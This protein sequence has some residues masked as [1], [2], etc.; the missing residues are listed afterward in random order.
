MRFVLTYD[1][2]D[3]K[4]RTKLSK[5]L[6]QFGDR[7]QYSVFELELPEYK[8]IE[9]KTKINRT[10]EKFKDDLCIFIYPICSSCKK[11]IHRVGNKELI[12]EKNVLLF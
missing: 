2:K 1:S 8:V 11:N 6:E 3:D 9:L 5:F 12:L 4:L 7:V 10:F